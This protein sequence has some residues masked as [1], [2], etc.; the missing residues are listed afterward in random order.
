MGT[1]MNCLQEK[2]R[3]SYDTEGGSA[4]PQNV[5]GRDPVSRISSPHLHRPVQNMRTRCSRWLGTPDTMA[6]KLQISRGTRPMACTVLIEE[7]LEI[8]LYLETL[9]DFRSWATSPQF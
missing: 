5:R 6:S 1:S 3:T 4:L 9:G 2:P 8:P 7:R